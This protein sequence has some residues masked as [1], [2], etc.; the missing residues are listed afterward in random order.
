M[1]I[2]SQYYPRDCCIYIYLLTLHVGKYIIHR[3]YVV[4]DVEGLLILVS[5]QLRTWEHE[6]HQMIVF[7]RI[8]LQF[9]GW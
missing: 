4:W 1:I 2:M 6:E 3:F 8:D 5:S 7:L 9:G